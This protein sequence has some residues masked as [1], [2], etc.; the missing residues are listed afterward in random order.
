MGITRVSTL[1][2]FIETLKFL[3]I[4]GPLKPTGIASISCSGG[5][6]ALMADLAHQHDLKF[7]PL[8]KQQRQD[9]FNVLGEKVELS[10][11]LDYHTYIWGDE[12]AQTQCFSAM[13]QGKQAIT[14]KILD[15]PK[16]GR[17]RSD[18]DKTA[19][20]FSQAIQQQQTKGAILSSLPETL[21]EDARE[22]LIK[23]GVAAMQGME[24]CLV[25]IKG[26]MQLY[27]KQ[28]EAIKPISKA[29]LRDG[30][31][32]ILNEFEGKKIL[33]KYGI[34]VPKSLVCTAVRC[35]NLS[36]K[37]WFPS[38]LKNSFRNDYS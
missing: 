17:N 8:S 15:Y 36:R 21:P 14:L 13:A 23:E 35:S 18:W 38:S 6:A 16:A 19:R 32:V 22:M 37:T 11:P 20:A 30:D 10:N 5:E 1:P 28:K 4:I 7:P 31:A 33:K 2:Q 9:L 29:S 24:E 26:A 3:S 12:E 27:Q 34:S 25:A